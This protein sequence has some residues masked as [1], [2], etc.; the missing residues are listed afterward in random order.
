MII[1][2]TI[3]NIVFPILAFYLYQFFEEDFFEK[4]GAKTS[5]FHM[6]NCVNLNNCMIKNDFILLFFLLLNDFLIKDSI[7][8]KIVDSISTIIVGS[9]IKLCKRAV[10]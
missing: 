1:I 5:V 10:N 4:I 2:L 7:I 9:F 6:S 8:Y 3:E